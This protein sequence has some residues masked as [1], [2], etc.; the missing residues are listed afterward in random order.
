[1]AINLVDHPLKISAVV[2]T[3]II[4]KIKIGD[5]SFGNPVMEEQRLYN[6][7]GTP[8]NG[9]APSEESPTGHQC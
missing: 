5:R 2:A 9:D 8:F 4:V 7:D 3:V 1:M 6:L